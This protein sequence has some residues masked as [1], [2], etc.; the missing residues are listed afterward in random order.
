MGRIFSLISHVARVHK[1]RLCVTVF[2][3]AYSIRGTLTAR[4]KDKQ[5]GRDATVVLISSAQSRSSLL[6]G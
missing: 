6:A 5:V 1:R 4:R 2:S 3:A